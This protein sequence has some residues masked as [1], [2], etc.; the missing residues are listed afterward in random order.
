MTAREIFIYIGYHYSIRI[1]SVIFSLEILPKKSGPC[2]EILKTLMKDIR[3]LL[4]PFYN[5]FKSKENEQEI[6][7]HNTTQHNT[8]QHNT[9]ILLIFFLFLAQVLVAQIEVIPESELGAKD[10]EKISKMKKEPWVAEYSVVKFKKGFEEL[11]ENFDFFLPTKKKAEKVRRIEIDS[12]L[13]KNHFKGKFERLGDGTVLELMNDGYGVFGYAMENQYYYEIHALDE[14]KSIIL[15]YDQMK[16]SNPFCAANFEKRGRNSN[17]IETKRSGPNTN[18]CR[19]KVLMLY[20]QSSLNNYSNIF[21]IMY[22]SIAQTNTSF[23]NSGIGGR[24]F[25]T[26]LILLN[27]SLL[28]TPLTHS[29]FET[30]TDILNSD[31]YI[32]SLR[33][34]HKADVVM[35]FDDNMESMYAGNVGDVFNASKPCGIIHPSR[36]VATFTHELGHILNGRHDDD[37]TG[38]P[39]RGHHWPGP[40]NENNGTIMDINSH[41]RKLHFSNPSILFDGVPTGTVDRDNSYNV[42]SSFCSVSEWKNSYDLKIAAPFTGTPGTYTTVTASIEVDQYPC[43]LNWY[44]EPYPYGTTIKKSE[45]I[46]T[47]NPSG[48]YSFT[49]PSIPPNSYYYVIGKLIPSIPGQVGVN[50]TASIYYSGSYYLTLQNIDAKIDDDIILY[51]N[52]TEGSNVSIKLNKTAIGN[53]I[54]YL[55]D[56]E[57]NLKQKIEYFENNGNINVANLPKGKYVLVDPTTKISR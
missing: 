27:E 28:N 26:P 33:T 35:L 29:N 41:F 2:G 44:A 36:G 18:N 45:T 56:N 24:I 9:T 8:T 16:F 20:S 15:R 10:K 6:F 38:L 22:N 54:L 47:S 4:N 37:N 53:G 13:T 21:S 43:T 17:R 30:D 31:P 51:P 11:G 34:A 14:E 42:N 50:T 19:I 7:K 57:G 49:F 23:S 1:I 5:I 40:F 3:L 48:V 39:G 52:P 25:V 32:S 55:F 46:S 12:P